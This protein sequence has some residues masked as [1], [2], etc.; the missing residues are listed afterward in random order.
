MIN[1]FLQLQVPR[2][3]YWIGMSYDNKKKDWAWIDSGPSNLSLTPVIILFLPMED[4][5]F[6]VEMQNV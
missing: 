4:V 6:F 1:K 5:H 3:N 2:N